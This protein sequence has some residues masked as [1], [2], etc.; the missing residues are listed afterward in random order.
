MRLSSM[1]LL[2][3]WP[4]PLCSVCVASTFLLDCRLL[5]LYSITVAGVHS[6][7]MR[8]YACARVYD[9][10]NVL[11]TAFQA[12]SVVHCVRIASLAALWLSL[13]FEAPS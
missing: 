3:E 13:C 9:N 8:L 12:H 4:V 11:Y 2:F 6:A 7:A 5:S 1:F 10:A